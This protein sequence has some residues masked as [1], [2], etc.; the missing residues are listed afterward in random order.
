MALSNQTKDVL[1]PSSSFCCSA[2]LCAETC[3]EQ[4][5]CMPCAHSQL[6]VS[7]VVLCNQSQEHSCSFSSVTLSEALMQETLTDQDLC[8]VKSQSSRRFHWG[9]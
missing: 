9:S 1:F 3:T 8:C 4:S 7:S 6:S 5:I 2:I